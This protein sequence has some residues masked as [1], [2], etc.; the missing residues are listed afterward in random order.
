MGHYPNLLSIHKVKKYLALVVPS[1]Y[2]GNNTAFTYDDIYRLTQI[3]Y[4]DQ[5]TVDITY[6]LNSNR[7]EMKDD[8]PSTGDY[9]L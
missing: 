4:E 5:S 1:I 7:T 8:S 9:S 6:D 2:K 3:L